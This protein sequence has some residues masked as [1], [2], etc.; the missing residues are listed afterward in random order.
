V[1]AR[2]GLRRGSAHSTSEV[3]TMYNSR[4]VQVHVPGN[5]SYMH[6]GTS[7]YMEATKEMHHVELTGLCQRVEP[8]G[9]HASCKGAAIACMYA[10]DP[11]MYCRGGSYVH[12]PK[13]TQGKNSKDS[14]GVCLENMCACT[15]VTN[16]PKANV[17]S[18]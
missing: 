12:L 9:I 3:A 17:S 1:R 5:G 2:Q 18:T 4:C 16:M 13:Y 6:L 7:L 10:R 14:A 11:R 8:T 15:C